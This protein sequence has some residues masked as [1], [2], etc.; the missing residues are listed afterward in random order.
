MPEMLSDGIKYVFLT[1][2]AVISWF[3]RDFAKRIE[4][5]ENY[6]RM[7][8]QSHASHQTYSERTFVTKDEHREATTRLHERLDVVG[9]DLKE[10]LKILGKL[11]GN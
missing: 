8:E 11:N 4:K 9:C 5:T 7:L 1:G 10:V 2:A 6:Q 3:L